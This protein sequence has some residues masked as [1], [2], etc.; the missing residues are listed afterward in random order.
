M[1]ANENREL[2]PVTLSVLCGALIENAGAYNAS[3][4]AVRR[5]TARNAINQQGEARGKSSLHANEMPPNAI[6]HTRPSTPTASLPRHDNSA[7]TDGVASCSSQLASDQGASSSN[8]VRR[9][10]G[11]RCRQSARAVEGSRR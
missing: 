4:D 2:I 9:I 7:A 3:A 6:V 10:L 5:S 1:P 11:N 8:E